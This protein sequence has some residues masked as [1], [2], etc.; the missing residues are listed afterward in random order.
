MKKFATGDK[1]SVNG[2]L[3]IGKGKVIGIEQVVRVELTD[4]YG[5]RRVISYN[6]QDIEAGKLTKIKPRKPAKAKKAVKP[7]KKASKG[8]A[9]KSRKATAKAKRR[10]VATILYR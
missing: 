9:S 5:D 1:V 3:A 4:K 10:P 2:D 7:V 8:K 6:A